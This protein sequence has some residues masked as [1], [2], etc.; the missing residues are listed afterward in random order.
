M[1]TSEL[2]ELYNKLATEAGKPTIKTWKGKREDLTT[3]INQL[4]PKG[5]EE[6]VIVDEPLEEVKPEPKK[7]AE[8]V[9]KTGERLVT[10]KQVAMDLGIDP[11]V[12]RAKLRRRGKA[13]N[14][15]RWTTVRHGGAEYKE[16][17]SILQHGREVKT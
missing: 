1:K 6:V 11:K 3:R 12:A 7:K 10:I 14:E 2:V 13:A 4:N 5:P 17:V 16:L 15:G 8:V 9:S